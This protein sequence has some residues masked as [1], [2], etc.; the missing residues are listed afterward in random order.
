MVLMLYPLN[1]MLK[2]L[3]QVLESFLQTSESVIHLLEAG[4]LGPVVGTFG[5][6]AGT[7]S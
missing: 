5:S 4:N 3:K 6:D 1:D 2:L 7:V